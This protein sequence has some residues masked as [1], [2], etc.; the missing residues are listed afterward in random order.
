MRSA[1]V[2]DWLV[3]SV[4]GAENCLEAIHRLF[5]SP[6]YTLVKRLEALK[7]TYFEQ[8]EIHSS[9]IQKFPKS[10]FKYRT[11][12][13]FFPLAI[14]QLDV[15]SY[16][17]ILSSSHCAAKGIITHPDQLHICYC[18]TPVRYAWDLMHFY[19]KQERL[20]KG[21][22]GV[23]AKFILHYF[24]MW[25]VHNSHRVDYFIANSQYV[26]QR[27]LKFYQ[28]D[29]QVIYPP[30][31]VDFYQLS[32][33]KESYY[34][35]A[36][37]FVPYKKMDVIVRAFSKMRDKKLIVVGDGPQ[38]EEVKKIAAPN[39]EMLGVQS[40]EILRE[41]L[42]KAKAFVF[43]ALEDFGILPVEAMA[44][45]T[46]VIAFGKGAV[47]E[48]VIEGKTG[49]FFDEQTEESLIRA[50]HQ[51]ETLSLSPVAC[52]QRAEFFSHEQFSF[53]FQRFVEDKYAQ[54]LKRT[55]S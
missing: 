9:F 54:F 28:R 34:V 49:L 15:S 12:L 37:R 31:Q 20:D 14:E 50:V 48:T 11:Y 53:Q 46:P 33:K 22:K 23:I 45:G 6:I 42:Q 43:C 39:V 38:W 7:G 30:V 10:A 36:S 21:L 8:M 51:F 41:L 29:A 32:E 17:L 13:P 47:R 35:A 19:L 1:I 52:R 3:S 5:P 25:D 24:R 18:H 2:H 16:D 55:P 4:G 26:K 44:S 27:I 40:K